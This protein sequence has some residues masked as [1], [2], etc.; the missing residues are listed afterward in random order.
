[1]SILKFGKKRFWMQFFIFPPEV[2]EVKK[3]L[4]FEHFK[5]NP[6]VTCSERCWNWGLH[7]KRIDRTQL[8]ILSP[9][10]ERHRPQFVCWW[11]RWALG[12]QLFHRG[13]FRRLGIN[14]LWPPTGPASDPWPLG[15]W[16]GFW[17]KSSGP[18]S[19]GPVDEPGSKTNMVK[20]TP[21]KKS[22]KI[23]KTTNLHKI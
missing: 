6:K 10:R 2:V 23:L 17:K 5:N 16:Q 12:R 22:N 18:M 1:M 8:R 14:I 21:N 4:Q 19:A 13:I 9:C 20:L 7:R 3:N 11:R 15:K